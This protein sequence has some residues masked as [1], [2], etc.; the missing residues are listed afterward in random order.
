MFGGSCEC[1]YRYEGY[2]FGR[3]ENWVVNGEER[4]RLILRGVEE[5]AEI[6]TSRHGW[7]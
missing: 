1:R 3:D 5:L 7:W 4:K 6:R 2:G